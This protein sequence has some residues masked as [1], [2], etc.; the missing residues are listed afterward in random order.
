MNVR[1][2]NAVTVLILL[3]A[4]ST[5]LQGQSFEELRS[6]AQSGFGSYR[7]KS[8]QQMDDF[9]ARAD[10]A[11]SEVLRKSWKRVSGGV[12]LENPLRQTPDITPVAAPS[13]SAPASFSIPPK[14]KI[15]TASCAGAVSLEIPEDRGS[16]VESRRVSF[17][18][19]GRRFSAGLP[20]GQAPRLVNC[21]EDAV[22]DAWKV[23][24]SGAYDGFLADLAGIYR[25]CSLGDWGFLRLAEAASA[26]VYGSADS[27]EAVLLQAWIL[28]RSGIRLKLCR[29]SRG[30]LEKLLAAD[31]MLFDKPYYFI[32]GESYF[33]ENTVPG[34][35]SV[36]EQ[37]FPGSRPM[38]LPLNA[39]PSLDGRD[40]LMAFLNDYPAFC[41]E[42]SPESSFYYI[43]QTPLS[44]STR[45]A[46]YPALREK[47]KG[48]N[49]VQAVSV[50]LSMLQNDFPYREDEKVWGGERYFYAE[51]TLYYPFSDCED[52]AILFTRL[53]RDLTGL[54][55]ALV[56]YP[57]HLAAA[58]HFNSEVRGG[59]YLAGG[60]SYVV[61]DPSYFG[62]GI[63]E[64][65]EGLNPAEARIILL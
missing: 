64:V 10:A 20:A 22:A 48:C 61:C 44:Q 60:R 9:R 30:R 45:S 32:D 65:M 47:L 52:R 14:K 15:E 39:L 63:G 43:A 27:D 50:L 34:D 8:I 42:G 49:E 62:A 51:E 28:S 46:R 29:D 21:G 31:A 13:G 16:A 12:L 41:D 3:L 25:R 4:C 23:L 33:S 54:S 24:S 18:L 37:S 58:V 2:C 6:K 38:H 56:Y 26:A 55:T 11:Y 40:A 19:Y 5:G 1:P 59:A 36:Q 57:G 35:I 17:L 7:E 53:V